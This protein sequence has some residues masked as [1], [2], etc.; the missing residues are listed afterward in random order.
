[1]IDNKL[2]L[3]GFFVCDKCRCYCSNGIDDVGPY[4]PD[5]CESTYFPRK[6]NV[7]CLGQYCDTP[8]ELQKSESD[9]TKEQLIQLIMYLGKELNT[10]L[11]K[12]KEK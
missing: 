7:G 10:V 8:C 5:I 12:E 1:M 3:K 6:Q 11:I 2:S 9:L 4:G